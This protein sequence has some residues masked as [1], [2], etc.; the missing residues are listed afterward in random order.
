RGE[1]PLPFPARLLSM[2]PRSIAEAALRALPRG[3]VVIP[4]LL[5]QVVAFG[6]QRLLPRAF[7]VRLMAAT[8]RRLDIAARQRRQHI[9]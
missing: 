8:I 4:G 7:S 6:L 2:N 9:G 3:G 5:N 1:P